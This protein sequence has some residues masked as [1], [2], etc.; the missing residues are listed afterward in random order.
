MYNFHVIAKFIAKYFL[1]QFYLK[2]FVKDDVSNFGKQIKGAT[3]FTV[4]EY[5]ELKYGTR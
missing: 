4:K 1:P 3:N 2:N 5:F